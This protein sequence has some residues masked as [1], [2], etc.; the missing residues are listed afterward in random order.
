[1]TVDGDPSAELHRWYGRFLYY[2]LDEV[3]L[4][5]PEESECPVS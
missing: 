5:A 3:E 2:R 1:V 4:L